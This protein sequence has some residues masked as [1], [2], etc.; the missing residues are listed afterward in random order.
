MYVVVVVQ[1]PVVNDSS[2]LGYTHTKAMVK[3]SLPVTGLHYGPALAV[4]LPTGAVA[5]LA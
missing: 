2:T 3:V 1:V 5:A 4:T